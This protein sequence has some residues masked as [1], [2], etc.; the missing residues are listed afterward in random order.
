MALVAGCRMLVRRRAAAEALTSCLHFLLI[1][2]PL[3]FAATPLLQLW[4]GLSALGLKPFV[5]KPEDRL[6]TVNTIKVRSGG[7][8]GLL[9]L[10][11]GSV[12]AGGQRGRAG[13]GRTPAPQ[14]YAFCPVSPPSSCSA[15]AA[16]LT[17]A[18]PALSTTCAGARGH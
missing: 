11:R 8:W 4:E 9:L 18:L 1:S 14:A 13:G 16:G 15:F 12:E 6:V 7:R 5:E 3:L 2:C 10:G 17:D